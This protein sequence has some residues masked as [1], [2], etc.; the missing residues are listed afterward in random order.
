MTR[1]QSH[2]ICGKEWNAH[3]GINNLYTQLEVS[4]HHLPKHQ[5]D[6]L[7]CWYQ[8]ESNKSGHWD[9]RAVHF[10]SLAPPLE[11]QNDTHTNI[12]THIHMYIYICTYTY[13]NTYTHTYIHMY[14]I[15][16]LNNWWFSH[17]RINVHLPL[18]S[19][20]WPLPRPNPAEWNVAPRDAWAVASPALRVG[21]RRLGHHM[22]GTFIFRWLVRV[23]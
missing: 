23:K 19:P 1:W 9:F 18:A 3:W 2:S 4:E 20:L 22:R 11:I 16:Q 10:H 21:P 13:T 15:Y 14:Y 8:S 12:F 6:Y 7:I 17:Q 5:Q